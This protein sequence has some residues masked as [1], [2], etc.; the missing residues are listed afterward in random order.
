VGWIDQAK[1]IPVVQVAKALGLEI[2]KRGSVQGWTCPAHG[3][4]HSDGRPSGRIVHAGK[5]WRCWACDASGDSVGLAS[6]CLLGAARPARSEW[7]ILAEWFKRQGFVVEMDQPVQPEAPARLP[8]A[9]VERLWLSGVDV[10]VSVRA[11]RWFAARQLIADGLYEH[12][13]ALPE[14]GSV[15]QRVSWARCAGEPWSA[16]HALLLPCVDASG[17][18]V[19][20]RARWIGTRR[21]DGCWLEEPHERKEINPR[22][23][24]VLRGTVYAGPLGRRLLRGDTLPERAW[25]GDVVIVEGGP[26]WLRYCVEAAQLRKAQAAPIVLGV[27]SG[28][29]PDSREGDRLAMRLRG[30]HVVIA[31]D[32]DKAGQKYATNIA[33]T[34][35]R[36]GVAGVRK[37]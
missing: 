11:L 35:R 16:G 15:D 32:T 3:E 7:P 24:G 19:G 20:L 17:V 12:C 34:L 18:R 9:E 5:G 8:L 37:Q 31:T 28:A 22:G 26:C 1:R 2:K 6:W 23:A 27:W 29:W 4:D 25:S 14:S 10:G 30:S 33:A 36:C 21:G 13:R